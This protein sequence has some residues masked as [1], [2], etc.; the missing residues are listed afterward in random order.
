MAA[1]QAY[2]EKLAK[3][4]PQTL[5]PLLG[6]E[7]RDHLEGVA[8]T[9]RFSFSEVRLVA[10]AARDLEMWREVPLSMWWPKAEA[11]LGSLAGRERKRRLLAQLNGHMLALRRLEKHYPPQAERLRGAAPQG[12]MEAHASETAI[13]GRCPAYSE[14]TVCCGLYTLDAALGCSFSCSYCTIQ[15]FYGDKAVVDA[16]LPRKLRELSSSLEP[17]RFYHIGTGQSSDSLILGNHERVLEELCAFAADHPHVLLEFKTKSD[18]VEP[19]LELSPPSNVV[20]SWTLNPQVVIDNEEHHTATL[21]QRIEAARRVANAGL[22]VA[23]HFHPMLHYAGWRE[24]YADIAKELVAR[25]DPTEVL[26]CTMGSVTLIKPVLREIRRRGGET[27]ILQM[28]LTPD[29][30]GKLTYPDAVKIV[31]Y[32]SLYEGLAPWKDEVFFYL[33]MEP[34]AI[35]QA[36]LG[37]S[38]VDNESFERAFGVVFSNRLST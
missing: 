18:R 31:L 20:C 5:A 2:G 37:F 23:F 30:H 21:A 25:F 38:H 19:L 27:K 29:P 17:G 16:E 4:L 15:T 11:S 24:G 8:T 36:S 7:A 14:R 1:K 13:F 33:C 3:I 34:E 12:G 26:F 28:D 6:E 22:K 35:W 10:E 32:R 9:Y